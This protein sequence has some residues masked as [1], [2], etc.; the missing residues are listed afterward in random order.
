MKQ[1][2]RSALAISVGVVAVFS[3][4]LVPAVANA[5]NTTTVNAVVSDG[6]SITTSGTVNLAITPTSGGSYTSASDTVTVGTNK[7]AGYNLKIKGATTTLVNGGNTLAATS[8]TFAAPSA[9]STVNQ[10]GY[11]VDNLGTFGAGP[12]SAQTDQAS[13][14]GT[15]AG[16]T[17]TDV[18]IKSTAVANAADVTTVWYGAS[19]NLTKPSGTYTNTI[20]YTATNN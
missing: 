18:Q 12:T 13:L 16:M 11:R 5:A 1:Q 7:T 6:I 19:A 9:M 14:S 3:L 17:T 20:T 10:W 2:I 15:W 4:V 8:G